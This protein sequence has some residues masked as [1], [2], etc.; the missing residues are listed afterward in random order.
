[1]KRIIIKTLTL[2]CLTCVSFAQFRS[3][4]PEISLPSNLNGELDTFHQ[5]GLFDQSR[6]NFS[7][8]FNLS[9]TTGNQSVTSIASLNNHATYL[10]SKNLILDANIALYKILLQYPYQY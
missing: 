7:Q 2:F 3:D 10:I 1:M 9:M 8:G 6:F 4:K 5:S